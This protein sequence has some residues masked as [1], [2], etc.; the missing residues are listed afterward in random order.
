MS[1]SSSGVEAF[2]RAVLN[3]LTAA[4]LTATPVFLYTFHVHTQ[5]PVPPEVFGRLCAEFPGNASTPL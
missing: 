4:E 5:Q 1:V 2:F 3:E